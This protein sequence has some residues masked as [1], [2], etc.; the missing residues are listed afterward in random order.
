MLA[1]LDVQATKNCN[2]Q[3]LSCRLVTI[4]R[5]HFSVCV[6]LVAAE[7]DSTLKIHFD[8]GYFKGAASFVAPG[9]LCETP[10]SPRTYRRADGPLRVGYIGLLTYN[11][12]VH[13]IARAAKKLSS[14]ELID[15]I[16]AGDGEQVYRDELTA[17]F[18]GIS[19]SF[20]GWV[21]PTDF[22]DKIDILVVPSLWREPFG[23][24]CIEAFAAGVPVLAS[25]IGGLATIVRD[26]RNGFLF[27]PGDA[28]HLAQ[29]LDSLLKDRDQLRSLRANCLMEVKLYQF[30]R[31]GAVIQ[32]QFRILRARKDA[33]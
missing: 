1:R 30:D 19:A 31:V 33:V 27:D 23:R 3:C 4:G 12:G 24:V 13:L 20:V 6:D 9:M 18:V 32:D 7:A 8:H 26:S 17:E 25:N 28:H 16:I 14:P 2:G 10:T 11:K 22:Y 29:L 15:F 21:A 5:K